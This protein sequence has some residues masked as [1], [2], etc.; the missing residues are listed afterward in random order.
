MQRSVTEWPLEHPVD[1]MR[2]WANAHWCDH[3]LVRAA[4]TNLHALG[5]GMYRSAQPS[6]V[7]LR[8]WQARYGLKSV[9]N[10]RGSHERASYAIERATCRELGLALH[11]IRL[12][13]CIPPS[14]ERVH[15]LAALFEAVE[16]PVLMHCKMG[17]DRSG[18]GSALYRILRLGHPVEQ[19]AEELTLGYGHVRRGRAGVLDYLFATYLKDA[20][21]EPIGFKDWIDAR[22][23]D[24]TLKARYRSGGWASLALE[25]MLPR[26]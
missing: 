4:W 26:E 8:R 22:Y 24:Q 21:R 19:A 1:R 3:G 16:Y 15:E 10:L 17:A 25:G 20:A 5:D 12:F 11:D 9:I 18:L 14:R 23:D 2:A 6:A 13:S 7:Q